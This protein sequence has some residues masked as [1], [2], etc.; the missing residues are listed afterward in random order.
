[1]IFPLKRSPAARITTNMSTRCS[2]CG[3]EVEEG[4]TACRHCFEPVK[5]E[6]IFSHFLRSLGVQVNV[7]VSKDPG[8]KS[9]VMFTQNIRSATFKVRDSKTGETREYHSIEEV[10]EEYR[11]KVRQAWKMADFKTSSTRITW[12]DSS[13]TVHHYNSVDELPPDVRALYEKSREGFK[14]MQ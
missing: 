2:K 1:M 10:P 3:A 6:G 12:T 4:W 11:E 5:R 13:G 9:G 14:G 7:S 8:G